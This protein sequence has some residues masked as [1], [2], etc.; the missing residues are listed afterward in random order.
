MAIKNCRECGTEVSSKAKHCPKCGIDKPVKGVSWILLGIGGLIVFS[1]CNSF[2]KDKRPHR[3]SASPAVEQEAPRVFIDKPCA[4]VT[5]LFDASSK[6]TELQMKEA[7]S[8]YDGK[9]VRWTGKV[10]EVGET[11]GTLQL[12]IK[13][14]PATFTSDVIVSFPDSA[15]ASLLGLKQGQQIKF[16]AKL[17]DYNRLMGVSATNGELVD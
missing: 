14:R 3:S 13:C 7:W 10:S 4:E 1:M 9:W 17:T 5:K 8:D 15:R 11:F 2:V 12:Q 16:V 6:L